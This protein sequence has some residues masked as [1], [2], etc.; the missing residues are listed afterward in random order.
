MREIIFRLI[1]DCKTM[2]RVIN[3]FVK[4]AFDTEPHK[5]MCSKYGN[6][7]LLIQLLSKILNSFK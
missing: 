6:S 3:I 7:Y 1:L 2:G 5:L 4:R